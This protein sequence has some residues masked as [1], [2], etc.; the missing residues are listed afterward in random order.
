MSQATQPAPQFVT[1]AAWVAWLLL[2]EGTPY[3]HQGRLPGVALDCIGPLV[4]AA[5]HFGHRAPGWDITGYSPAPDGSLQPLLD[6]HLT[7]KPREQLGLGDVVLNA[8]R[9]GPPR[10]IAIIVGE[11]YG[12]WV[13]L[14]ADGLVGRVQRE[15]LQY[16]RRYYR[17]VQGYSVPWLS[18]EGAA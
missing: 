14:H 12:Q 18:A 8:F 7:R 6:E 10:H 2:L 5:A 9:L 11:Q 3:Q 1:P 17:F 16:E 15:R 4:V 13:M